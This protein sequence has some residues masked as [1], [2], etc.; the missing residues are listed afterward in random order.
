M[1]IYTKT[2]DRGQTGLFDGTRVDKEDLR[3]SAYGDVDELNSH[4]GLLRSAKISGETDDELNRIQC[5]LFEIGGDLAMPGSTKARDFL[6]SR[7]RALE[8]WIDEIMDR[9]PKLQSF[10]MP[11]GCKESAIAHVAR[12]V[13]RRAERSCW[14]AR[15]VHE[16]PD[17]ILVYLNRLS[18]LL[19]ALARDLNDAKGVGDVPWTPRPAK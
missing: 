11:G 1:S 3:V 4:L 9:L 18:D 15:R 6:P 17:E 8:Q 2:G 7:I 13:C 19:F 16:F 10:V 12:T 5:D 14:R